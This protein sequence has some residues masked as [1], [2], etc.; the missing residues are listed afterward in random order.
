MGLGVALKRASVNGSEL[1]ACAIRALLLADVLADLLQFKSDGGD[2]VAPGPKVFA[3]EI[4]FLAAQPGNR[5]RTLPF[6][7]PNDRSHWVLGRNGDA[8]VHVV[9]HQM[10][11]ENWA[12]LLPR[13]TME[14]W[15]Q[16]TAG[17]PK[18]HFPPTF[19]HEHH[20]ILAVPFG[21]G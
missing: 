17:L 19:R 15:P 5:N 2:G 7:K 12:F 1:S 3:R 10:P 21:M 9:W 18:D 11:F 16:L 14:N 4:P 8:H 6:E 20:V 13:Q